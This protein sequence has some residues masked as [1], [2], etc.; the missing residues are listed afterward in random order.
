MST[1]T[2]LP[3][4]H[5]GWTVD[6]LDDLPEDDTRRYELVDGCL[7]VSPSPPN[8]HNGAA[9]E[10]SFLLHASIDPSWRIVAPGAVQLD[11]R[12]YR[13]PDLLVLPREAM[14]K[15]YADPADALLVVEVMSPSSVTNDRFA[16]P[17]QYAQAGIAH[18]WRIEPRDRVLVTY[19]LDDEA[20]RETG[21]FTDE[22][23]IDD[24]VTLRFRLGTLL[25]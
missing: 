18:Y 24:P 10:L 17:G 2:S 16:K 9:N 22:V 7:L 23:V 6:D 1:V 14:R 20:Y 5:D 21:R 15:K 12:N 13:E 25:D 3:I 11:R 8:A 4:T 19:A